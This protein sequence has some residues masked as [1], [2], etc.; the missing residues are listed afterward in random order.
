MNPSQ[1]VQS[2]ADFQR[3]AGAILARLKRSGRPVLLTVDGK[4]ELVVQDAASY[5]ALLDRAERLE[6]IEAVREGLASIGKGEGRP[7]DEVFDDLER[8]ARRGAGG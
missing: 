1:D 5:R 3:E 7:M 4:A 2:L 6:T 8:E